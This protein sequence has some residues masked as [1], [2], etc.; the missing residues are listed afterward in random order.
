MFCSAIT[1]QLFGTLKIYLFSLHHFC[2]EKEKLTHALSLQMHKFKLQLVDDSKVLLFFLQSSISLNTR[3]PPKV[4]F[5]PLL[6]TLD[7]YDKRPKNQEPFSV[8]LL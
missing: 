4:L 3:S 5:A 1:L 2:L 6:E 7:P 8:L